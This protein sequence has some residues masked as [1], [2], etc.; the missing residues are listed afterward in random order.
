[1]LSDVYWCQFWILVDLKTFSSC[2]LPWDDSALVCSMV[3]PPIRSSANR[4]D[5]L[6]ARSNELNEKQR[7]EED[8]VCLA[9]LCKPLNWM[10]KR[11][12]WPWEMIDPWLVEEVTL[13]LCFLCFLFF[14]VVKLK[15]NIIAKVPAIFRRSQTSRSEFDSKAFTEKEQMI[16][17][18]QAIST[19]MIACTRSHCSHSVNFVYS[20]Y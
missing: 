17:H 2:V 10:L 7:Y 1:M 20:L 11:E 14:D 9:C 5:A 19:N 13:L 4:N 16:S 3:Q 15:F 12:S 18:D 6:Q 8:I